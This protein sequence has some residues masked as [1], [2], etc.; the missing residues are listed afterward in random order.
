MNSCP[1]RKRL[2]VTNRVADLRFA[3]A[4]ATDDAELRA[5][6]SADIMPGTIAV[7]FRREPSFFTGCEVLGRQYQVIK[8]TDNSSNR[9]IGLGSRYINSSYINGVECRTGYLADL[10]IQPEYRRRS[11]LARGYRFLRELHNR[12][13]VPL[14]LTM[15]LDGNTTAETILTS[16]RAGLPR[17]N[18]IG[19]ISTP[20]I[21][22]GARKRAIRLDGIH[23]RRAAPQDKE[24]IFRFMA[25]HRPEKQLAQAV[26]EQDLGSKT[27]RGLSIDDFYL[28]MR[29]EEIAGIIACWDQSTYRQTHIE[30]YGFGLGLVRPAYN[31][32]STV[33]P[34]R[35][36]PS[37]GEKMPFFY[38]AFV[39]IEGND[40]EIFASL[41]RFMYNDRCNA[42]WH[43]FIAGFHELDPLAGVLDD[44]RGI[45]AAGRLFVVHYPENLPDRE[46]LDGRIP[47][48][49]IS[50]I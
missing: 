4:T 5:R 32:V 31:L 19:K 8:C 1:V 11:V 50:M 30:K 29:G 21:F 48:I 20:A 36:L 6:M 44:Y 27:L 33:T 42:A 3:L 45:C 16:G 18:P 26:H 38:L 25:L 49:E 37:R 17:Y 14:Y 2:P 39:T 24:S 10:R 35:P 23:C 15:I 7:S 12:D 41:L 34:Y 9:I 40:R 28:A 13:P 46:H 47:H 43:Y 22:L